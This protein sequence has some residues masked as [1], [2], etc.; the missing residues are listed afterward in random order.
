MQLLKTKLYYFA[1]LDH[2]TVSDNRKFWKVVSLQ[3]KPLQ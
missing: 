1:K 2:K 3:R